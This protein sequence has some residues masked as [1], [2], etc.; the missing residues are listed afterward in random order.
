MRI[1][2]SV[3]SEHVRKFTV[4]LVLKEARLKYFYFYVFINE[5]L[6]FL[7]FLF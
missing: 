3:Y 4:F 7:S 1:S 6:V 2:R 5:N